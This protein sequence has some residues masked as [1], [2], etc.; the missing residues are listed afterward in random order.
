MKAVPNELDVGCGN[1]VLTRRLPIAW[2]LADAASMRVP[3]PVSSWRYTRR[4]ESGLVSLKS[5]CVP[6]EVVPAPKTC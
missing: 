6:P 5:H 4:R 3:D 1:V 2:E